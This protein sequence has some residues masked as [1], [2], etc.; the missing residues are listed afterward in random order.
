MSL[1]SLFPLL[2]AMVLA[3]FLQG[4]INRTKAVAAGRV[5]QPLL[6]PYRDLLKLLQK[7]AVYSQTT[8][9]VFRAGPVVGLASMICAIALLPFGAFTALAPFAGDL[10]MVA[11]LLALARFF[12]VLPALHTGPRFSPMLPT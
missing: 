9:W 4:V 7:G 5:G 1:R 6:Q 2:I 3:P 10:V 8:T 11:Y 12:T